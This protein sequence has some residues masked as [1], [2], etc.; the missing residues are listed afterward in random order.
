VFKLGIYSAHQLRKRKARTIFGAAKKVSVT[1]L[2][3]L[4]DLDNDT[5]AYASI[6]F[7]LNDDRGAFK[8]T[9]QGRFGGFDDKCIQ[10]LAKA[11]HE[12]NLSVHDVGVSSAATSVD[13]FSS[14]SLEF[15]ELSYFASD[16]DPY[17]TVLTQ[18][19]LTVSVSSSGSI[20]EILLPPFVFNQNP[21]DRW[22][23]PL[24]RFLHFIVRKTWAKSVVRRFERGRL[25]P[26]SIR[27]IELFCSA[28]QKLAKKD[29]RFNLGQ[30]DLLA[31]NEITFDC[32]RA[33]NVLNNAYFS[34][35]QMQQI[36]A[37]IHASLTKNGILIVG[38]NQD[39]GSPVQGAIYVKNDKGFEQVWKTE[40]VPPVVS[41]IQRFNVR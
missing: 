38:S 39:P 34:P 31:P 2:D 26:E 1:L 35:S 24:N 19:P 14:L 12:Q 21:P 3:K 5:D 30:Y 25:P 22:F 8:R 37:N 4:Q 10:I 20:V 36:L 9:Y 32:L 29:S 18:N 28:A 13:F 23:Y 15:R 11:F 7:C 16:Y 33:M 41:H 17:L 6:M 40:E 27:R